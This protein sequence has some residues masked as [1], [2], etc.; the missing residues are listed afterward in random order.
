MVNGAKNSIGTIRFFI[1]D[2]GISDPYFQK[3]TSS[4]LVP[5]II[6]QKPSTNSKSKFILVYINY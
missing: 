3:Y 6:L 1:F 2:T 5:S 4:I